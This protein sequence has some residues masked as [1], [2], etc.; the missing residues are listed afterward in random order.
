MYWNRDTFTN[1][2]IPTYPKY[3][4]ELTSLIPKLTKR[5][6]NLNIRN[7]AIA[8]GEFRN[9]KNAREIF[10]T[11]LLQS[12]NNVV[13]RG[14]GQNTGEVISSVLDDSVS[15]VR[16]TEQALEFF[17]RF[18]DPSHPDY[19]WNRGLSSS[20][21]SFLSGALATYFGFASEINS[22]RERNPNIDYDVAPI[23]QARGSQN[24]VTFGRMHGISIVRSTQ[25][26]AIAFAVMEVLT[27][28]DA[29]SLWTELTYLPPVR[30]DVINQGT[31]DPYL[32]IFYDS[33]LIA[34]SWLDP[35]KFESG[36]IFQNMVESVTSGKSTISNSVTTADR[37]L[38]DLIN[39]VRK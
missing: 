30:R 17:T 29:L 35:D 32:Q 1:A 6:S 8:L 18:A 11:L 31:K 14:V 15:G 21:A 10:G 16:P 23:P 24:R 3:W 5:D 37:L 4:D 9:V 27:S 28:K 12:G 22:L 26:P 36:Q 34:D 20:D 2:L 19:S 25:N 33:A 7:T 38:Q 13:E 39:R